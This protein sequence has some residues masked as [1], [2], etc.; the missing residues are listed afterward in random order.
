MLAIEHPITGEKLQIANRDFAYKMT[1]EQAIEACEKL[2]S[3]WRLPTVEELST[4]CTDYYEIFDGT[5]YWSITEYDNDGAYAYYMESASTREV[6][7]EY[8]FYI[9]AVR[10][11]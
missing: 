1:W 4:I 6:S 11:I 9:R 7:K 5:V 2:G 8:Q 10:S 3:G